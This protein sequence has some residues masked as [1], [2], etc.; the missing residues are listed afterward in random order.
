MNSCLPGSSVPGNIA[1][2][3]GRVR[4]PR[5]N[6][7][8]ALIMP[9]NN[10]PVQTPSPAAANPK[11]FEEGKILAI[12]S[13]IIPFVFLVPIIQKN[14]DYALFHAKQAML[15]MIVGF[16]LSTVLSAT[17]VLAVLVPF[18]SLGLLVLAIMGIINAVKGEMKPL[19]V[20]GKFAEDWFKGI[21]K[22]A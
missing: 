18:V 21:R 17:C 20:L 5:K 4:P 14:N 16:V 11:E 15:L 3:R 2:Q 9:D 10:P 7:K 12:L 19:P 6:P 22:G 8:G 1:G 13:Y